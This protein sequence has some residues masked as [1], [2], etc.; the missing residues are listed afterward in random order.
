[1]SVS[2]HHQVERTAF[3]EIASTKQCLPELVIPT[4]GRYATQLNTEYRNR[5]TNKA[6]LEESNWLEL[7]SSYILLF[8]QLRMYTAVTVEHRETVWEHTG[9]MSVL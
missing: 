5:A 7:A 8:Q 6:N 4:Q 3:P 1:M 2:G 9:T